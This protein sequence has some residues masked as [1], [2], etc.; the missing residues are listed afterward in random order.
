MIFWWKP[1]PKPDMLQL[2]RDATSAMQG[3]SAAAQQISADQSLLAQRQDYLLKDFE[4]LHEQSQA[5][6]GVCLGI[7]E[8]FQKEFG[9]PPIKFG[10]RQS[11]ELS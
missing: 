2:F 1:K 10:A 3:F 11:D 9:Y 5:V 4:K 8:L 7:L 6:L